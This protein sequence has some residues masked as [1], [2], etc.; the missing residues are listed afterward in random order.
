M[1]ESSWPFDGTDTTETQYSYLFSRMAL[2]GVYGDPST[3]DLLPFGDSSGM[4]VKLN[5]GFA[6]VRG[7]MYYN[8][9]VKTIAVPAAESQPR[10]DAVVITLDPTANTIVASVKKGTAAAN[11]VAPTLNQSTTAAYEMLLGYI[12]VAAS[13]AT[14]TAANVTDAR[15]FTDLDFTTWTNATRPA[16]NAVRRGTLGYNA[17]TG[18]LEYSDGTNWKSAASSS[19]ASGLTTGTLPDARLPGRLGIAGID[20]SNTDIN[21]TAVNNGFYFGSS[22]TNSPDATT[23]TALIIVVRKDS[24]NVGQMAWVIAGANAGKIY[25][26]YRVSAGWTSWSQLTLAGGSSGAVTTDTNFFTQSSGWSIVEQKLALRSGVVTAYVQLK[27]TGA[28]TAEGENIT[29]FQI[30]TVNPIYAPAIDNAPI[31][32]SYAG[33]GV[34]GIVNADGKVFITTMADETTDIDNGE[35]WSWSG[36]WVID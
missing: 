33:P 32:T 8:D 20:V 30:G 35:N 10:I 36:T 25:T 11:P 12:A 5:A 31:T 15:P 16:A 18:T 17:T 24:N 7:F 26:R 1:T 14:I 13:A 23:A 34:F 29:N 19:D 2:T 27:R 6:I 28:D 3:S 21:T 9:A 22:M 4:Q